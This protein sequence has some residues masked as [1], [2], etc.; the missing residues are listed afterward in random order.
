MKCPCGYLA[1]PRGKVCTPRQVSTDSDGSIKQTELCTSTRVHLAQPGS[2]HIWRPCTLRMLQCLARGKTSVYDRRK[3][4][5]GQAFNIWPKPQWIG[6][7]IAIADW[8]GHLLEKRQYWDTLGNYFKMSPPGAGWGPHGT[9]SNFVTVSIS[10]TQLVLGYCI[11][12][13][14]TAGWLGNGRGGCYRK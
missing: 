10:T 14:R 6:I 12:S 11:L 4:K 7:K 13:N 1:H 9:L 3:K 2:E 5:F 8:C